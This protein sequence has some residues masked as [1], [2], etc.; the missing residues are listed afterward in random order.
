MKK[1]EKLTLKELGDNYPK[2]TLD[3]TSVLCGGSCL[4]Y[5]EVNGQK[6]ISFDGG[7]TWI[8]CIGEITCTANDLSSCTFTRIDE[9]IARYSSSSDYDWI[10][11]SGTVISGVGL[12]KTFRQL[13]PIGTVM[14]LFALINSWQN[15]LITQQLSGLPE[16]NYYI[17]ETYSNSGADYI[18]TYLNIFNEE[19]D[20]VK[21][22]AY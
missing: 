9:L 7:I 5:Q 17:E 22:I 19:G 21:S 11:N 20:F 16:G 3:E 1:L 6:Q 10:G 12:I 13:G 14:S 8:A 2:L 15:E 4:D 18:T